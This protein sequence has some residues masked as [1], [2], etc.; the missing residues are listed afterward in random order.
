MQ[1]STLVRGLFGALL[2][3]VL[4]APA[5]ANTTLAEIENLGDTLVF[6][7]VVSFQELILTV[8]GPCDLQYKQR[9]EE[10]EP[11]FRLVAAGF[12]TDE[13]INGDGDQADALPVDF[14]QDPSHA[15]VG[16]SGG[17]VNVYIEVVDEDGFTLSIYRMK[18][19]DVRPFD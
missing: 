8:T 4:V 14:W 2:I 18:V 3:L 9:V 5:S 7:P 1:K 15:G 19:D 10:G 11:F 6:H 16:E 17:R 12:E 13:D